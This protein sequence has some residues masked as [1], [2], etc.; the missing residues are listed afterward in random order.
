[1]T[2]SAEEPLSTPLKL[3]YSFAKRHGVLLQTSGQHPQVLC[4][5]GVTALALAEVQRLIPDGLHFQSVDS[6]T[7]TACWQP[8]TTAARSVRR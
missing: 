7:L 3:P 8:I 2:A 1:M 5:S 6:E 4:R